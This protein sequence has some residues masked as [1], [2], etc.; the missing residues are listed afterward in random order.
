MTRQLTA[1]DWMN[2]AESAERAE[3]WPKALAL[4]T[5]AASMC[6]GEQQ[7]RCHV[8]IARCEH[9]VAVDAELASIARR[10]LK[11]PTLATRKMDSLDFHEVAVWQVLEALR[12]AYRAGRKDRGE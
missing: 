7:H 9:E 1:T 6:E 4:W 11:V 8:G 5:N 10:I 12:L 2:E 3:A